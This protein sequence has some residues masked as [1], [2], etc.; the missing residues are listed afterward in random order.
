MEEGMKEIMRCSSLLNVFLPSNYSKSVFDL[1]F[2]KLK[3]EGIK[4][5]IT[6]LDNTLV[7]WDEPSANQTV[8]NW[9]EEAKRH[10]IKVIIASNNSEERVKHFCNPLD[11]PYIH[12]AKKPLKGVYKK[13]LERLELEKEEVVAIGDQLMT[14]I[15]GANLFGVKTI[16]VVP[17]AVTDGLTTKFNRMMERQVLKLMRRKGM[18]YWEE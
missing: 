10:E 14:D 16:L 12:R 11:I 7:P 6:D 2:A 9:I 13:A 3:K 17:V 5:I 15:F 4:G 1:N 18:V 8:I